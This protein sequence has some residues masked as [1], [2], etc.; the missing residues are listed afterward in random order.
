MPARSGRETSARIV[1]APKHPYPVELE[2]GT[3]VKVVRFLRTPTVMCKAV[4]PRVLS[5]MQP[6]HPLEYGDALKST[7][8]HQNGFKA[9]YQG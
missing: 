5:A 2:G 8:Q 7:A 6:A 3:S 1:C 4:A 9:V